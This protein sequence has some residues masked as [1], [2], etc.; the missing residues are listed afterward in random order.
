MMSAQH[1][2]HASAVVPKGFVSLT[3]PVET[4][5]QLVC[6]HFAGGSAQSFNLFKEQA[7]TTCQVLAAE[8]PGRGRR[9]KEDF[10]ISIADAIEQLADNYYVHAHDNCVLYGHSLGGLM[11]FEMAHQL[12]RRGVRVSKLIIS[13]RSSP[14]NYSLNTGIPA[15]DD[16]S[17]DD[18]L[19]KMDGTSEAVLANKG[20][21][22][23]LIPIIKSDLTLIKQYTYQHSSLLDIPISVIGG[24]SDHYCS[25]ESLLDWQHATRASFELKMIQ[26]GHFSPIQTPKYIFREMWGGEK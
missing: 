8:L 6:F 9:F 16:V 22:D 3:S 21:M 19:R 24:S 10:A 15:F 4:K 2:I 14:I 12:T 5:E 23:V 26:G 7:P 25:F 11:A 20:L 13:S 1:Q 17:I 18:Y